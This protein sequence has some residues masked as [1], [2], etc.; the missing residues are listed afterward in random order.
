MP[1]MSH[2]IV[3]SLSLPQARLKQKL[4]CRLPIA[5]HIVHHPQ[6][7]SRPKR[8]H[9]HAAQ[10]H[11]TPNS[12][13]AYLIVA[14][15]VP[16]APEVK[17]WFPLST[18]A[19]AS[20]SIICSTPQRRIQRQGGKNCNAFPPE[21]GENDERRK[22]HKTGGNGETRPLFGLKA[23]RDGAPGLDTSTHEAKNGCHHVIR[24]CLP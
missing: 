14:A 15:F 12:P 13:R 17:T 8:V 9:Y 22:K 3:M 10:R 19:Y 1:S 5:D 6:T 11:Q 7:T 23:Q 16:I 4:D 20:S 21:T 18:K 2:V 24:V